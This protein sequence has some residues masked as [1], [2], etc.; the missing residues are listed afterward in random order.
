MT[1]AGDF[2]Q[3]A[4]ASIAMT[5]SGTGGAANR[6]VLVSANGQLTLDGALIL[7]GNAGEAANNLAGSGYFVLFDNAGTGA[8]SGGFSSIMLNGVNYGAI[9]DGGTFTDANGYT[10]TLSYQGNAA[11]GALTGGNDVLLHV[12]PEPGIWA[13]LAGGLGLLFCGQRLRRRSHC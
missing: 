2:T 10:Y 3:E 12:V 5:L 6:I 1:V 4:G 9:A 13:L 7:N 8:V 11:T